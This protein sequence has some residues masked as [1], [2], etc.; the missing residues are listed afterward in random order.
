M[1]Y[2]DQSYA[3]YN[4]DAWRSQLESARLQPP[5]TKKASY[6]SRLSSEESS[7]EE[8]EAG[9][10]ARRASANASTRG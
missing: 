4:K 8:G 3:Y 6:V 2:G 10:G 9:Q 7:V 5:L 1:L